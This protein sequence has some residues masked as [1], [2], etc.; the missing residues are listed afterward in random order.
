MTCQ[1][2]IVL[3]SICPKTNQRIT[4]FELRYWR[5]IHSELMTH[6][7]FSRNAGSSRAIPVKKV[8]AQVL[9]DPAGPIHWGKNQKGM[10]AGDQLQGVR[11]ALAR[12][13]WRLSGMGM[14]ASAWILMKVG[15]H[16]QVANRL[17]EPWQYIKVVV[18]ATEYE[19]WFNLRAHPDAMP[20]IAEL[21]VE[22]KAAMDASTPQVL[23]PGEWHLPYIVPEEESKP[24]GERIRMAVARTARTSYENHEGKV[25]RYE[26]DVQLHNR[27]ALHV[28][29]HLS[30]TEHV[31]VNLG[32]PGN[33]RVTKNFSGWGQYRYWVE[34]SY[35][36]ET[37]IVAA[38]EFLDWLHAEAS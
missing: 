21:A 4:T 9:R 22:M 33:N 35:S 31:A 2:K 10:Q 16:K 36:P 27:L 24:L 29:P 38:G 30:P 3:D 34:H 18:T 23:Q 28:P 11:L 6:R 1:V 26:E 13:L 8:L 7:V 37:A 5:A 14:A 15:L 12:S 25:P 17:L 19:N 32:W 20:E